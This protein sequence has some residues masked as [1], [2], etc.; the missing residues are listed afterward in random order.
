MNNSLVFPKG[1]HFGTATA[2]YQVPYY[3]YITDVELMAELEHTAYRFS[4]AWS[5]VLPDGKGE[6]SRKG[7]DYYDRLVDA[8][9][10]RA[11]EPFVT[12]FHWDMPLALYRIYGGFVGRETA[13]YFDNGYRI[14]YIRRYL[15]ELARAVVDGADVRGYFVWS[16]IDNFEWSLGFSHRMGLIHATT[17][18]MD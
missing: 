7:L 13:G 8:L 9:A 11:V 14:T 16:L 15:E 5:R 3:D 4:V 12:L 17:P 1:F 10:E 6:V 2:A 18:I